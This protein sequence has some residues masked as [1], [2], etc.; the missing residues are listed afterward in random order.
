[1]TT[2]RD[3]NSPTRPER[4]QVSERAARSE[5]FKDPLQVYAE[6]DEQTRSVIEKELD[7]VDAL[8]NREVDLNARGLNYG[9]FV[10]LA[11]LASCVYLIVNGHGVEGTILGVIFIA[12]LVAV[13]AVGRKP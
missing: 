8:D 2:V 12:A 13:L 10:T 6:A 1:M 4:P 5:R 7:R 9:I 11:F 3:D